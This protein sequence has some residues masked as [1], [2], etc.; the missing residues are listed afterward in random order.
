L[1]EALPIFGDGGSFGGTELPGQSQSK[2]AGLLV[3]GL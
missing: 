2:K 3:S 1:G